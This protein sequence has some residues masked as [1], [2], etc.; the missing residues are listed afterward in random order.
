MGVHLC[1]RDAS[2][3]CEVLCDCLMNS[4]VRV[5]VCVCVCVSWNILAGNSMRLNGGGRDSRL[6]SV[7]R[8]HEYRHLHLS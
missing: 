1:D 2:V 3:F 6:R 5:C 7:I 4:I 8:A